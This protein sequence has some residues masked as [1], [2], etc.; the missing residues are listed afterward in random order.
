VCTQRWA[1]GK[2]PAG[3]GVGQMSSLKRIGEDN[4]KPQGM[5]I[6]FFGLCLQRH[7][8]ILRSEVTKNLDLLYRNLLLDADERELPRFQIKQLI[9]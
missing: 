2:L 1:S 3:Q 4:V 8:V 7:F 6:F 9:K 5:G